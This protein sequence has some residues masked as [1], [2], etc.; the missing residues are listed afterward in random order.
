MAARPPTLPAA[1]VPVLVG[2]AAARGVLSGPGQ[3]KLLPF[4]AALVAALLIQIGT[5]LANDYFDYHKGA[6][7]SSRLGPVRVTQSAYVTPAAVR[8]ATIAVFGLAVLVGLYLVAVGGWPILVI[9]LLSIAAGVA[10]T[11]GPWPLGYHGLGDVFV[12]VFF[13]LVA[14]MGSAYLQTGSA[15]LS[16]FVAAVPVGFLTTAILVVNN[17]RDIDT[18]RAARKMTLAVRLGRRGTRAEYVALV[19][20][21]YVVTAARWLAGASVWAWLPWLTLPLAIA[22]VRTVTGEEGRALNPALKRTG[23]LG[24]FF[25]LLFSLSLLL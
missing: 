24:L 6:D 18:D 5:N 16:S 10:Y 7:T 19:A 20:G 9:G 3:F 15:T 21:A 8:K 1:I 14:V 23:Q 4:L 12:F 17:L 11:G 13:G 22:L 25:G 2:T